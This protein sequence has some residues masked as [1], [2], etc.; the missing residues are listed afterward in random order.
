MVSNKGRLIKRCV[1]GT[2]RVPNLDYFIPL[3]A[4]D[5]INFNLA[6]KLKW[7]LHAARGWDRIRAHNV[8]HTHRQKPCES[9]CFTLFYDVAFR[10]KKVKGESENALNLLMLSTFPVEYLIWS[11][12]W[13]DF[14]WNRITGPYW[15]SC[16]KKCNAQKFHDFRFMRMHEKSVQGVKL[17]VKECFFL[18]IGSVNMTKMTEFQSIL[19]NFA[20]WL[21]KLP[22]VIKT[23][24]PPTPHGRLCEYFA[25]YA[26][27]RFPFPLVLGVLVT[28]Q[29]SG[30]RMLP[31]QRASLRPFVVAKRQNHHH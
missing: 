27:A 21:P 1:F 31:L 14:L 11:H 25:G 5:D 16:V 9:P 4:S 30:V 18:K 8:G 19:L 20:N 3:R 28:G 6:Y 26:K 17:T 24:P 23:N 29:K 15:N 13:G 22:Y 12:S 7:L 2:E 10:A